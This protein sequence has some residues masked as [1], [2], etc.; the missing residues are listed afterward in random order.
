M[1]KIVKKLLLIFLIIL[2]VIIIFCSIKVIKW[3]NDSNKTNK[4]INQVINNVKIDNSNNEVINVEENSSD[5]NSNLEYNSDT[6]DNVD[7]SSLIKINDDTVGWIKLQN[8]EVN[9][10]VVQYS[11]NEYYLTH[12]FDKSKNSAGWVFMDYRN[13]YQDIDDNTIIYAHGRLDNTMFGS[14]KTVL[15][16][17]WYTNADNYFINFSTNNYNSLW[18][19]FSIYKI[20]TTNDYLITNFNN[21]EDFN[22]FINTIKNRSIYDF[23]TNISSDNKLITLSTCYNDEY[24]LVVH[25]KLI[26]LQYK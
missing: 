15:K 3:I 19:I 5:F 1:K 7:L 8:T 10:P 11:D 20:K 4:M 14:L 16:E 13:N 26:K 25:A 18:Q 6:V 2:S 22:E 17:E 21:E 12:S 9:Y 24:K 23:Q